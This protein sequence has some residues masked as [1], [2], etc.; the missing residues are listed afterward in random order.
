[1]EDTLRKKLLSSMLFKQV[2]WYDRSENSA[3]KL[4]KILTEDVHWLVE[5]TLSRESI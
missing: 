2:S 1:M 5:A 4:T 3:L